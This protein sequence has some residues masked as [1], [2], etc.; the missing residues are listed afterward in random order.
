MWIE[1]YVSY[2]NQYHT[3][4]DKEKI[5]YLPHDKFHRDR[6]KLH[7]SLLYAC[8]TKYYFYMYL[9]DVSMLKAVE[10]NQ[11]SYVV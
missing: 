11:L 3:C 5:V 7:F 10:Q 9:Y 4:D 2:I 1:R 8:M 6:Y